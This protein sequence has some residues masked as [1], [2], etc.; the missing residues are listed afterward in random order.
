MNALNA[1][2]ISVERMLHVVH[3]LLKSSRA[4]VK[5]KIFFFLNLQFF[6]KLPFFST[7]MKDQ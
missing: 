1:F 4:W 5:L 6:Y 3:N 7:C 2:F